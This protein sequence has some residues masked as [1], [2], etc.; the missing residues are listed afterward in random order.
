M[1]QSKTDIGGL[2]GRGARAVPI[3]RA[4][5]IGSKHDF[6]ASTNY[7]IGG[8]WNRV[9]TVPAQTYAAN[10]IR[11]IIPESGSR[12]VWITLRPRKHS[13]PTTNRKRRS[14]SG[15]HGQLGSSSLSCLDCHDGTV[16]VNSQDSL[17]GGII[18]T[19]STAAVQSTPVLSRSDR[20]QW[21]TR[22]PDPYASDRS[23][24]SPVNRC[25]AGR[26]PE[27]IGTTFNSPGSPT[28]GNVLKNGNVECSSCH[29]IH[30]T[31]AHPR[32]AASTRWPPARTFA[33]AAI[34]NKSIDWNTPGKLKI[35]RSM[36]RIFF[37]R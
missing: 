33:S 12:T 17:S 36:P 5:I 2:A 20:G 29:D 30:R 9:G 32:P 7:W 4:T 25:D 6:Y 16:A 11:F 21:R 24:L 3:G 10:A 27:R 8:R 26:R 19:T 35:R 22:R 14:P 1:K 18:T 23:Q 13:R 28:V 34:I 15:R 37:M 31:S